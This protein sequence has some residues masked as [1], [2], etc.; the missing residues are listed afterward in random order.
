MAGS[1]RAEDDAVLS[2]EAG[3]GGHALDVARLTLNGAARDD[4]DRRLDRR[5][6]NRIGLDE[7]EEREDSQEGVDDAVVP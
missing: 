7:R 3:S 5:G 6:D 2:A 1:T 4:E